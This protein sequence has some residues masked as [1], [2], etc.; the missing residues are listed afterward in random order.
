MLALHLEATDLAPETL[1]TLLFPPL[2][3]PAVPVLLQAT[4][5]KAQNT[6]LMSLEVLVFGAKTG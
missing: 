1:E 2:S 6:E 3:I 5:I 4:S